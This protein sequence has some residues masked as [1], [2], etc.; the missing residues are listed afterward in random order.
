MRR[1]AVALA[2]IAAL[3]GRQA[4]AAVRPARCEAGAIGARCA[5]ISVPLDRTRPGGPRIRI[6]FEQYRPRGRR[7]TGTIVAIEGGP[8]YPTSGSRDSYIGLF[9]PLLGTRR[10]ILVDLRGTGRSGALDCPAFHDG[11]GGY[12]GRAGRC[13]LELGV[14]RDSYG[15]GEAAEDV[16]DV[17][18]ALGAGR[19]DLYGDSYGTYAAQTFAYRHPERLRSLV[20]DASYPLPGTDPALADLASGSRRALRLA[21]ARRPSCAARHV[22]PVAALAQLVARVR[23][24][25]LALSGPDG[26]GVERV[27]RVDERALVATVLSGAYTT[28]VDR[29]L[30][31]ALVSLDRG[32]S[33]P[34]ARV[35]AEAQ[36][37]LSDPSA[38]RDYS[39]ALYLA[40]TCHDY[41]QM[42]DVAAPLTLRRAQLRRLRRDRPAAA[43]AP[44]SAAAWTGTDYEGADACLRWPAPRR[45]DPL[46]PAGSA[47]PDVPT[48]VLGGDLDTV[49]PITEGRLVARRF[50]RSRLVVVQNSVHVTAVGDND[51]CAS[52]LVRRFV[53]RLAAGDASCAAAIAEVRVVDRFPLTLA[54]VAPAAAQAGDRSTVWARRVAEAAAITVSDVVA[55]WQLNYSG[56][57]SGLRSGHATYLGD[58]RVRFRLAGASLVP[59]VLVDGRATWD[60]DRGFVRGRVS[61][62]GSRVV[63]ALGWSTRG[64]LRRAWLTGVSAAGPLRATMLAP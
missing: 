7:P 28:L 26:D 56:T 54:E 60:R 17:L 25:P 43:F 35:V 24:A 27:L 31:A 44:F 30:P 40:V 21:C 16:E 38:P 49:T 6:Y 22:D 2:V 63:V 64:R 1:L 41:P 57:I 37:D 14:R 50:P 33:R 8:G 23:R 61:V 18:R 46:V 29:D 55:R 52:R 32:D 47:P 51:R 53:R 42:W 58:R 3:S 12:I 15:T 48:L 11:V 5:T 10:L 19:V 9:R 34:L 4:D 59:G 20:L 45:A 36:G 62:R 39:E 13:A